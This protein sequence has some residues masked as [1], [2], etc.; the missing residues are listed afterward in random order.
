MADTIGYVDIARMFQ[1]ATDMIRA[2]RDELSKLDSAIG[3]GDHGM[4]IAR[5][6]DIAE[7]V[8]GEK[9]V[10]SD[11]PKAEIVEILRNQ[12]GLVDE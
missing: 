4:T 11:N 6:M 7:K 1:S 9:I 8:I 10:L 12:Y 5:A 3:D 2:Q